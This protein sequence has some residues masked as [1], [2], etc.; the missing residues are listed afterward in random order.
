MFEK[1]I[2]Y[3]MYTH[4]HTK[5]Q[6]TK[7]KKIILALINREI[8]LFLGH[9][10]GFFANKRRLAIMIVALLVTPLLI[11]FC[12]YWLI[13]RKKERYAIFPTC[14]NYCIGAII[15]IKLYYINFIY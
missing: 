12:A 2:A 10:N 8:F 14:V 7:K 4:T 3:H 15:I 5:N 9:S 11:F 6:E 1:K 13:R